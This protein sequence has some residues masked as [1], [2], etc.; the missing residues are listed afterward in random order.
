[1]HRE[2]ILLEIVNEL[3]SY[4]HVNLIL[5]GGAKAF[6]R[7]DELSD[8]DLM[9]GVE[10]DKV[11]QCISD[12]ENFLSGLTGIESAF[13][14]QSANGFHHR[15]YKHKN[16][17][18]FWVVDLFIIEHSNPGKEQETQI[19]GDIVI[20]YDRYDF[21]AGQTFDKEAF[22]KKVNAYEERMKNVF[23]YF[24]YQIEKEI[25]RGKYLDALGYY[26]DLTIK[27]LTRLL[28]IKYNPVHYNFELRYLY[29]ELPE[30]IVS[31][32]ENLYS[33]SGIT[34]L[35]RKH[36]AAIELYRREIDSNYKI[37]TFGKLTYHCCSFIILI[38]LDY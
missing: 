37:V 2:K 31:E 35:T 18:K 26:F 28:R 4:E 6:N 11:S 36:K 25:I 33:V 7:Y 12:F 5:E 16:V 9:I 30:N 3:R 21:M 8:I 10:D 23:N 22:Q 38:R 29:D 32:L 19:H 27:P 14:P 24:Q 13:I 15:F 34:D 17:L 1:M 20:H